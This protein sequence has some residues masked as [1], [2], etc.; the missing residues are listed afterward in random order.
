MFSCR[1]SLVLPKLI[2]HLLE[3]CIRDIPKSTVCNYAIRRE[4]DHL[5]CH[6]ETSTRVPKYGGEE[7]YFKPSNS[8]SQDKR[9][10]KIS[11]IPQTTPLYTFSPSLPLLIVCYACFD[12]CVV[13]FPL[14]RD[15]IWL[16][17][18]S[19]I[20]ARISWSLNRWYSSSPTLTG[21]PPY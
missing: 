21:D 13:H 18:Y 3:N 14:S 9:N 4:L 15:L 17:A 11:S 6:L 2:F 12:T 5:I 16:V 10:T 19:L 20:F 7:I 1:G 8:A